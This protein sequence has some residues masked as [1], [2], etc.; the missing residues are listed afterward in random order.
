MVDNKGCN[1][2]YMLT[3]WFTFPADTLRSDCVTRECALELHISCYKPFC[4]FQM[5]LG[6]FHLRA[7]LL[8]DS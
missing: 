8:L 3:F 1:R 6:A 7:G 2:M 4:I 5:L